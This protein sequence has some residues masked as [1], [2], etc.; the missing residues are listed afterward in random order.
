MEDRMKLSF[1]LAL[2]LLATHSLAAV[3]R[4]FT[5]KGED[6][7]AVKAKLQQNDPTLKPALDAF[8]KEADKALEEGPFTVVHKPITPPSGDKH[9]Y[10]S[11]SPYWFPNPD[12]PDGLP[13]VR[14]DGVVNPEREKFDLPR[15]ESFTM[16]TNAL[17]LAYYFTGEEKYATKAAELMRVWFFDE[18][19]RM[20]PNVKYAQVVRGL[21]EEGRANGVLESDRFRRVIDADALLAGSKSW[22]GEDSAKLRDWIRQF[23]D[24]LR[25]SEQG[26]KELGQKNNHGSWA[27]VQVATY[28][29]YLGDD[30]FAKQVIETE[31]KKRIASQIEPDGRQPHELARTKAFDYC[32]YNLMALMQLATL[33]ERAGV[34]L[35]NYKTDDGRSIRAAID[36]LAPYGTGEKQWEYEQISD[37][38]THDLY[39]ILR[40]AANAYHEP[41]YDEMAKK[42]KNADPVTSRVNLLYPAKS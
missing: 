38:K 35:W 3:P 18:A 17:A 27:A 30:G 12:K 4:T 28:A 25:T 6:L 19:T 22:T 14:K 16:N 42:V 21:E 32:R 13:Y 8:L 26:R 31:G 11:L 33:G 24:Y 37:A 2:F 40:R 10:M 9:D 39:N 36:W 29:L 5:V 41:K 34:D 1:L 23:N 7:A 15:I 20:N